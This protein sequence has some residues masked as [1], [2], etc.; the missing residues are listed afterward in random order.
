MSRD[1]HGRAVRDH[2]NPVVLALF[3]GLVAA[4]LWRQGLDTAALV[5]VVTGLLVAGVRHAV[6]HSGEQACGGWTIFGLRA[7]S[8]FCV[9]PGQ[10]GSVD[11]RIEKRGSRRAR[12]RVYAVYLSAGPR[13]RLWRPRNYLR[14][15]RYAEALARLFDTSLT[16]DST[17][18]VIRRGVEAL[19]LSLGDRLRQ[20]GGSPEY[21]EL[22]QN[23]RLV[24]R[25]RGSRKTLILASRPMPWWVYPLIFLLPL[26]PLAI[27][28]G[29]GAYSLA[30]GTALLT[31]AFWWVGVHSLFP[32]HL[33]IDRYGVRYRLFILSRRIAWA[34]LEELVM[35]G[36]TLYLLGDRKRLTVPYG[37]GDPAEAGFVEALLRYV[38]WERAG[39]D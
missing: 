27:F 20:A 21:P 8:T 18:R 11:I 24:F 19:D 34:E 33:E 25:D 5:F 28:L 16:D 7:W 9:A 39:L 23:G 2:R 31:L 12:H 32:L 6:W 35:N 36:E 1:R 13:V 26:A 15:R 38:A 37:F 3:I 30:V 14:A 4:A 29:I 22:P 10:V 17:G